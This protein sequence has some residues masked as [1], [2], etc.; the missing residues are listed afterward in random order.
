MK[1]SLIHR[2]KEVGINRSIGVKKHDIYK[3]FTSE[4]FAIVIKYSLPGYLLMT[5]ANLYLYNGGLLPGFNWNF[6]PLGII[7]YIVLA[8]II[9][10]IP[11]TLLLRKTPSEINKKYDI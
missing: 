10:L 6:V 8:L 1:S 2:I 3:I 11:V 5:L 9:G 7:I 4:I